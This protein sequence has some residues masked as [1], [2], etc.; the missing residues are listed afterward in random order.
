[1]DSSFFFFDNFFS[2]VDLA[3]ALLDKN[4]LSC[5]TTRSNRKRFPKKLASKTETKRLSRGKYRSEI[6]NG[7]VEALV[8]NDKKEVYFVNTLTNPS[9]ETSVNRRQHDGNI[10]PVSCP[11]S[12]RMYNSKMG[13]VDQAD[14]K[15]CLYTMPENPRSG[16]TG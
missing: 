6:V 3:E 2:S 12:V 4:T 7:R 13:G 5:A 10:T 8:W 11:E 15:R 9:S 16:G 14:C 1:M